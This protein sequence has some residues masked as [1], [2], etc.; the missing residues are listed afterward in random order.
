MVV[1]LERAIES[2]IMFLITGTLSKSPN[3][4]V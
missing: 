3:I 4:V 1:D 2:A